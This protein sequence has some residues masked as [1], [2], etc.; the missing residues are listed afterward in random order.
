MKNLKYSKSIK[1]AIVFFWFVISAIA[2]SF[3]LKQQSASGRTLIWKISLLNADKYF[4]SGVENSSF[5]ANYL[6]WQSDYFQGMKNVKSEIYSAGDTYYA[7]NELLQFLVENGVL[8]TMTLS[9]LVIY[10]IINKASG[11]SQLFF[12]IIVFSSMAFYTFHVNAINY[13][14]VSAAA[15]I[16]MPFNLMNIPIE[17]KR[18]LPIL[19]MSLATAIL[20]TI[21]FSYQQVL[22]NDSWRHA[23][24]IK[25]FN[26]GESI[27]IYDSLSSKLSE[28]GEYLLEYAV[29]LTSLSR[30]DKALDIAKKSTR[31]ITTQ[32]SFLTIGICND[33]IGDKVAAEIY[34]TKAK[35]AVPSRDVPR[36]CLF[37]FYL[38][39]K[40]SSKAILE[41]KELLSIQPK[42]SKNIVSQE[43][44][45]RLSV[46]LYFDNY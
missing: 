24:Y 41:A 32:S 20:I 19:K 9:I 14:I 27:K 1:L 22:A 46:F 21:Y 26:E 33:S 35:Y 31:K 10:L 23:R 40:D 12:A 38:R 7:F 4:L 36:F 6:E 42:N 30:Y 15:T 34:Y 13:L 18:L 39:H 11:A 43:I 17:W 45:K 25:P 3:L 44:R 8:P 28:N 16:K 2:L 37:N 5:K 29:Q